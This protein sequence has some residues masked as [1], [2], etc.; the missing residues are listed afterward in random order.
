MPLP[1]F[2]GPAVTI[3]PPPRSFGGA[4]KAVAPAPAPT[5]GK[6]TFTI[7]PQQ[8][9][10]WCWAAVS[11][12]VSHFFTAASKWTQCLI[13]NAT[14]PRQD[15]CGAGAGN[16]NGCNKPW[17][18]DRALTT[19]GNLRNVEIRPLNFSEVQ[20]EIQASKPVGSRVGWHGGGGHFMAIVGWL[21]ADSG[22]QYLDI[23]DPIF[24]NSQI[25]FNAY[26]G[27]YQSGGDWTHSY[28]T[29][30]PQVQMALVREKSALMASTQDVLQNVDLSSIG[31]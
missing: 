10:N 5:S 17:Y 14:L 15:C 11:T 19:A 26:A 30:A 12:S 2:L 24:L 18:L 6:L 29:Q 8:Q 1:G 22:E 25:P 27:A 16:I 20:A 7:Q 9:T 3:A 23:A 21:V 13:A 4:P 28:L 31:A